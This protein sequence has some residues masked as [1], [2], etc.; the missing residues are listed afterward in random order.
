MLLGSCSDSPHHVGIPISQIQCVADVDPFW[1]IA[2]GLMGATSTGRYPFLWAVQSE[3]LTDTRVL[4]VPPLVSRRNQI[5]DVVM[6]QSSP[7]DHT[8]SLSSLPYSSPT[9]PFFPH[10]S[11]E[12]MLLINHL[13]KNL[14]TQALLLQNLI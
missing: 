8:D 1:R 12:S 7:W 6:H 3:R 5:C 14:P 13:H 2:L 10:S 4:K 9:L 11:S